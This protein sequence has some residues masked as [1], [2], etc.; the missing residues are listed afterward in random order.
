MLD[1]E[2]KGHS[3]CQVDIVRE[4]DSLYVYK[5]T[6]DPGYLKRLFLQGQKQKEAAE[7][8]LQHIRVPQVYDISHDGRS[9][10]IKMEY[11]YSKS[12][13]RYFEYAGFEQISYFIQALCLYL[14]YEIQNS[15]I[16]L[17][18]ADVLT[19]KFQDVCDKVSKNP[20]L[21]GDKEV[22]AILEASSKRFVAQTDMMIPIGKCHG[23]LTF[24]NIL[25]NGNNYYLIDFLDSFV[26][27]P[28][29]DIV[30]IRQDSAYL[31]SQLM[32]LGENDTLRLQ[33][34]ADK[35][36][37]QIASYA[38]KFDWFKY[39]PNFQLMNFLRILQY[40]KEEKIID[41]LKR[42]LNQLLH[43]F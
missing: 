20:K 3:G 1:L 16:D 39:Y 32:Y 18:K 43:E 27:S 7:L 38:S 23:D 17:V 21:R 36:D 42:I 28:L 14:D 30:K 37:Q 34:V 15:P 9:V 8:K 11:V 6:Q 29:L 31:W 10:T 12:F 25:F 4:N 26:E 22:E 2:V 5:S 24:S 35:I 33:I 19:S 40:A 41:Y 13:V